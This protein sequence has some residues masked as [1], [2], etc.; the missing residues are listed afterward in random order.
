MPFWS[1]QV[2]FLKVL[3]K[4]VQKLWDILLTDKLGLTPIGKAKQLYKNL[5]QFCCVQSMCWEWISFTTTSSFTSISV[6]L[7][8]LW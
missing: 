2:N 5:D 6:I 7:A 3:L 8:E 1:N 4:L